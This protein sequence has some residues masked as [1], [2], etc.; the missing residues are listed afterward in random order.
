MLKNEWKKLFQSKFMI[1]VMIAVILIPTIYTVIFVGAMWDPYG[2]VE[3]LPVAVVNEDKPVVYNEKTLHVG[4]DLVKNLKE[5]NSLGFDFVDADKAAV[6][7]SEGEYYMVITIPEDFSK[8][9]TTLTEDSS[10]KMKLYYETNPG[11]NY[12]ASKMSETAIKEIQANIRE[13]I[14]TQYAQTMFQQ[15]GTIGDG[16]AEA[17]DGALQITDGT[18]QLLSGNGELSNGLNTLTDG[19]LTLKE[20][21]TDLQ[22][23][24][25]TYTDGV[26][27]LES[28]AAA[29]SNKSTELKA[30]V[31][32]VASGITSLK[33]GSGAILAGMN[34]MSSELAKSL[35]KEN[36]TT[37]EQL[38]GGLTAMNTGIQEMNTAVQGMDVADQLTETVGAVESGLTSIGG[39]LGSAQTNMESLSNAIAAVQ[40][41]ML[42]DGSLSAE[43]QAALGQLAEAAANV[44]TDVQNIG[45][46]TQSMATTLQSKEPVLTSAAS[47]LQS[48]K[49]NMATLAGNANVVLPGSSQAITSLTTGLQSVQNALDKTG[50]TAEEM[51]MIQA[52]GAVDSGLVQLDAGVSGENGL[53][54]GVSAYTDGVALVSSGA[55]ELTANSEALVNGAGRI[56]DGAK[57]L[58][59]GSIKL[60]DG[61]EAMGDGLTEL[62]DGSSTLSASLGDAADEVKSTRTD[63]DAVSMFAAPVESEGSQ[64]SQIDNNG[65]AMAAY[66]MGVGL[67]VACIAFCTIYPLTRPSGEVQRGFSWWS[68]K[69]SVY[70][71]VSVL[72]AV[73]MIFM[74]KL[75]LGFNPQ[76]LGK[77]ILVAVLASMAFM[78]VMYF[79][80]VCFG[81]VG[82]YLMLIFMVLQLGG[83]AGTYPLELS[84][85][86]YHRIHEHM[87]FTYSVEAFRA[88]ISTG[89][90]IMPELTVF[91]G[92]IVVFNLCS[93]AVF[94]YKSKK[95]ET[96]FKAEL[97]G[98]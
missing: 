71:A 63:E 1:V 68:S 3:N 72:Q 30:G 24:L 31:G 53:A 77:T 10:K 25:I 44:G 73:V 60:A 5:N 98:E 33:S 85:D 11:E 88:T 65:S 75:I 66:M 64:Y 46:V 67:W 58:N 4:K 51:G 93:L 14:T 13:K 9:A 56:T 94:L 70:L 54:A 47:G 28:G 26:S 84:S 89:R 34:T 29:L 21:S 78:S 8:N 96:Q 76:Y 12:I 90:D 59:D 79:F 35:S 83:S 41:Q 23:G 80:N 97:I 57:A 92:M 50:T 49:T 91:I 19:T 48:L 39:S 17:A 55:R 16:F 95:G 69:A 52:M 27:A 37:M 6:G 36:V 40:Q 18:D 38:K 82:S 7:L 61:S 43:E 42:A 62:K 87:P 45:A 15:L 32:S 22:T 74:L 20:G 2:N 86:F 81:K